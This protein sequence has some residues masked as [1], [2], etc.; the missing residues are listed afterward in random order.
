MWHWNVPKNTDSSIDDYTATLS[1][2]VFDA[3]KAT[4]EGTWENGIVKADLET[5]AN[6]LKQLK[7]A[8]V[9]VLW[10]PLTEGGEGSCAVASVTRSGRSVLLVG[11]RCREF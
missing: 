11:K 10:R 5:V 8:K 4:E 3:Q 7:E 9:P 1:E 2:T 6:M